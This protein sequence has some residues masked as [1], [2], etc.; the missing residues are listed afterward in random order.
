MIDGGA[1]LGI[2]FLNFAFFKKSHQYSNFVL[3][4]FKNYN[5]IIILIQLYLLNHYLKFI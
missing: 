3:N 1:F 5:Y 4:L 2:S